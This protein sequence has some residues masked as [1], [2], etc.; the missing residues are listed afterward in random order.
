[1]G[2]GQDAKGC[3]DIRVRD[4]R[5]GSDSRGQLVVDRL[6]GGVG[7]VKGFLVLERFPE[8]ALGAADLGGELVDP[9]VF[10]GEFAVGGA[11]GVLEADDQAGAGVVGVADGDLDAVNRYADDVDQGVRLVVVRLDLRGP[12]QRPRDQL[13]G[14]LHRRHPQ[15]DRGQQARRLVLAGRE[16]SASSA[17]GT[18]S[19]STRPSFAMSVVVGWRI[20]GRGI[21]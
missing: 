4:G 9:L 6:A 15:L 11:Q 19:P 12:L 14:L 2:A 18:A 20:C 21:R 8:F 10:G 3:C 5:W 16:G 7:R 1:M 13:A 17:I